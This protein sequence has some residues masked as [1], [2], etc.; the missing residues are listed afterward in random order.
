MSGATP[1]GTRRYAQRMNSTT[2]RG[3][4]RERHTLLV[5][6]IG[7]GTYLGHWDEH[8]DRSY[9]EAIKRATDLGCNVIDSAINYRF[10]RS[11]RAIGAALKQQFEAG[12]V[13]RDEIIVATKGGFFPFEDEPPRDPRA[14]VMENVLNKGLAQV[15]DIAG[16]SHCMTPRY[17]EDQLARSLDNLGLETIDIYY[18]HNPESQLEVVPRD[19]FNKRIRAAF[20]VLEHAAVAGR[21]GSYGTATWNG[22]RQ[23][24]GSRG[25]LSLADMVA[26]A[27][28]FGGEDHHFRAIQ[29]PYNLAMPEALT[30]VNQLVDG[31][32][33]SLLMAAD[34][35]GVT[36]MCSASML[37]AKLS[38]N[39][40]PFVEQALKGLSTDA[41]RAIQFVRST[42]C[43][44]TALVGMSQRSHV[45]ENM[46]VARVPV[47]AVEEFFSMF[48]SDEA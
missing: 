8:T 30:I 31:E 46:A 13:S 15:E 19:E 41:Q 23:Q 1:E 37:Q 16:G 4:F 40:P 28:E 21:I 42:P 35:L 45:D 24:P 17:L 33:L 36:V 18:I 7:L 25:H 11:E 5:S 39:L 43:V 3:H 2:A 29:L 48:S 26:I 9:E 44:T 22:Y 14:W 12:K 34:R 10:Q 20:E 32:H 38:Q 27:R 47:A 6:S